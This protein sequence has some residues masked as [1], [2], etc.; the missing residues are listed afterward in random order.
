[1]SSDIKRIITRIG[2]NPNVANLQNEIAD[3]R[4]I[5]L[6]QKQLNDAQEIAGATAAQLESLQNQAEGIIGDPSELS[7]ALNASFNS[8]ITV[9]YLPDG[10]INSDQNRDV[11]L[12]RYATGGEDRATT[13]YSSSAFQESKVQPNVLNQFITSNYIFTIGC[14]TNDELNDPDNTYRINGPENIIL[15]SGGLAGPRKVLTAYELYGKRIEFFMD[16]LEIQSTI[17]PNPRSRQTNATKMTWE[18]TEPFSAGLFLQAL[19]VC[20]IKSGHRNFLEAPYILQIDFVGNGEN[21]LSYIEPGAKKLIPFKLTNAEFSLTAGGSVYS[22]TGVPFNESAL[23]DQV[24][25]IPVDVSISGRTVNEM[26]QTGPQSLAAAFNTHLLKQQNENE[27]IIEADEYIFI[28]PKELTSANSINILNENANSATTEGT[29]GGDN[30]NQNER[31]VTDQQVREALQQLHTGEFSPTVSNAEINQ[32]FDNQL[33]FTVKRSRLSEAI[34]Q[35]NESTEYQ[36]PI[37]GKEIKLSD[38]LAPGNVP[39]GLANFA[40]DEETGLFKKGSITID[41]DKRTVTFPKDTRIQKI[42]EEI[43]LLSEYGQNVGN[44]DGNGMIDWFKIETKV[45][46]LTNLDHEANTGKPPRIYVYQV[47]PYKVHESLFSAPNRPYSG[48]RNMEK[49]AVKSYNYIYSGKN[50][51]VLNFDLNFRFAFFQA[52]AP[53]AGNRRENSNAESQAR[54]PNHPLYGAAES[55]TTVQGDGAKLIQNSLTNGSTVT[56]GAI[57]ESAEVQIARKFND[58]LVNSDV[59]LVTGDLEIMG[60]PYYIAD[61]GVGNYNADIT[62]SVNINSDGGI[63]YQ[64][65]QVDILLNFKTPLDIRDDGFMDFGTGA[66]TVNN[67]SG[68]YQVVQATHTFQGGQFKQVLRIIRRRNQQP[69]MVETATRDAETLAAEQEQKEARIAEMRA[70]GASEREV[71]EYLLDENGDGNVTGAELQA[72]DP[73]AAAAY[74][75]EIERA[76]Y[77]RGIG[78]GEDGNF[79]GNDQI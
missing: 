44:V 8:D 13:D 64:N 75:Q 34:K 17:S 67:F 3:R 73:D 25:G 65:G 15:R 59:D 57:E 77:L 20:A 19:E 1:M 48:Y 14:L 27:A 9:E 66:V 16:N 38:P 10:D 47:V 30:T 68:L 76:R 18:I 45:F 12:D 35:R 32:F 6:A 24:Q 52:L 50:I 62:T 11:D 71:L 53:D 79:G 28:F 7:Q 61:S 54:Q 31:R 72:G 69:A 70:E 42:L 39:F 4:L 21:G 5:E 26:A 29:G 37:A 78:A 74:R 40:Y 36:N 33:G 46:N 60:D 49:D 22:C 23:S 51:D 43:V 63:N 41:P 55:P 56:A 2:Q 58:A